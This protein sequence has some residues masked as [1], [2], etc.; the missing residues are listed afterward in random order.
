[1]SEYNQ[2]SQ[3]YSTDVSGLRAYVTKVFVNMA[4]AL[5]ITAGVAFGC[6]YSL[7]SGGFM[8][9]MM[10]SDIAGF[11]GIFLIIAEFGVVIAFSAGVNK[12]STTTVKVLM[13]V[14]AA[15]TGLTFTF[16]P[17]AYGV[18]NVFEAFIFAAVLFV[19]C[20]VIGMY[21]KVNLLKFSGLF[22][23]ALLAFVVMTLISMFIPALRDG[24][25][26][27]YLGLALFLGLTAWDMQ[28]IKA[29][30]YQLGDGTIKENFAVYSAF[31]LY[32]DF[33]N[34]FLFILRILG[35]GNSDK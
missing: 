4:I 16:L 29:Y 30:Y 9:K 3:A 28:K 34:V 24:L 5:V 27:G 18:T 19:C 31:Q 2:P 12:F 32:L 14:Y 21:T 11:L 10:S 17:M 33:I 13:F 20:A 35:N 6:Y 25:L 7:M 1:M 8:Y 22:S 26:M 15:L 23:G